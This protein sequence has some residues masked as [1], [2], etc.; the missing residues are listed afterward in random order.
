MKVYQGKGSFA[1]SQALEMDGIIARDK[2]IRI[3]WTGGVSMADKVEKQ[4]ADAADTIE[5]IIAGGEIPCDENVDKVQ[6]SADGLREVV[7]EIEGVEAG[8]KNLFPS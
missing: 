7:E 3:A 6:K 2:W 4:L 8:R 5:K 1:R